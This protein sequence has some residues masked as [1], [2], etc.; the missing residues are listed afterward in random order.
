MW[1]ALSVANPRNN[2]ILLGC[3]ARSLYIWGMGIEA[4]RITKASFI[5]CKLGRSLLSEVIS[6]SPAIFHAPSWE[7]IVPCNNSNV[8]NFNTVSSKQSTFSSPYFY[9]WPQFQFRRQIN[10]AV[11]QNVRIRSYCL[12]WSILSFLE[13]NLSWAERWSLLPA[14]ACSLPSWGCWLWHF[15][16]T[17]KPNVPED[18]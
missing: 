10:V 4:R 9:P 5:F 17:L 6:H 2:S 16:P 15:K 11:S 12:R 13:K 1:I 7:I 18:L 8:I 3:H 14:R